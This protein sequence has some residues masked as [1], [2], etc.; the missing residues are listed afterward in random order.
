MKYYLLFIILNLN[1]CFSLSAHERVS[2]ENKPTLTTH[3]TE[4]SSIT[5]LGNEALLV[6]INKTKILFDPF[7]AHDFGIYQLVPEEMVNAI[8]NNQTPFND[9]DAVI[10]SHAHRDH[11]SAQVMVD[12]LVKHPKVKLF[13]SAQAITSVNAIIKQQNI[14][15]NQKN[16]V[17]VTLDFGSKPWRYQGDNFNLDA[18][19]IPHAGWPARADVENLIFR[20]KFANGESVMHMGDADPDDDHY[21][22]YRSFWAQQQVDVN[23]PPYWFF[24]SAEGRDILFDIIKAKKN[25][26]IHVPVEV[27]KRLKQQTK[28]YFSTPGKVYQLNH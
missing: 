16:L 10:I 26:G 11:F 24:I 6:N 5:Y 28:D 19:R 20:V 21:L 8:L 23:F 15:L 9:I 4:Q 13:A 18:V 1:V 12:Y 22:P 14:T 2:D 25:I 17:A 27:P 3:Q 7:F